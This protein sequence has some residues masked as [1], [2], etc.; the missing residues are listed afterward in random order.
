MYARTVERGGYR[1]VR[2][3]ALAVAAVAVTMLVPAAT[4][5]GQLSNEDS[6]G[7]PAARVPPV[8]APAERQAVPEPPAADDRPMPGSGD[9][10]RRPNTLAA[11]V[12]DGVRGVRVLDVDPSGAAARAGIR[13]G[14][15]ILSLDGQPVSSASELNERVAR[16]GPG[17]KAPV[18]VRSRGRELTLTVDFS[19]RAVEPNWF[20]RVPGPRAWLGVELVESDEGVLVTCVVAGGPAA[21]AGIRQGDIL[22]RLDDQR[23]PTVP[24]ALHL[25]GQMAPG[26]SAEVV[27]LR[28]GKESSLTAV[29]GSLDPPTSIRPFVGWPRYQPYWYRGGGSVDVGPIH[30][31]W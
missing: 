1:L 9:P 5:L 13:P 11:L 8:P 17:S 21:K 28:D 25:I 2:G 6:A 14:D 19:V 16:L 20:P 3:L 18:V 4:V 10:P 26:T 7:K 22:I 24:D 31:E 29:M 27:V 30:V 12:R 15:L 23:V